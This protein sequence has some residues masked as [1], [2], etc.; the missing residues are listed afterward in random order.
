[1]LAITGTI[2]GASAAVLCERLARLIDGSHA[3]SVM[4]DLSALDRADLAAVDGLATAT[5]AL[6]QSRA[7]AE[8]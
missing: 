2:S 3:A 1:M 6:E 7:A 5:R 4:C 8:K